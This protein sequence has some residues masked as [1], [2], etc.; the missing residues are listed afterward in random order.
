MSM[1]SIPNISVPFGGNPEDIQN[2]RKTYPLLTDTQVEDLLG[3]F[4]PDGKVTD[5]TSTAHHGWNAPPALAPPSPIKTPGFKP[6]ISKS[7]LR[8]S[9]QELKGPNNSPVDLSGTYGTRGRARNGKFV[10]L[11]DDGDE[12]QGDKEE[13]EDVVADLSPSKAGKVLPPYPK[14]NAESVE[15][16]EGEQE[17]PLPKVQRENYDWDEDIF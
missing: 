6:S 13:E 3:K 1:R 17:K 2:L 16:K 5:Y 7:S 14:G 9:K 8:N 15:G 10:K 12:E 11:K 4:R